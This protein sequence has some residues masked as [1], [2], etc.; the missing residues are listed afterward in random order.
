MFVVNDKKICK[1]FLLLFLSYSFSAQGLTYLFSHGFADTSKQVYR[2]TKEYPSWLG[3]KRN[4]Y[5]I[6]DGKVKLFDYPDVICKPLPNIFKTS[7]GQENEIKALKKA[8]D[9]IKDDEIVLIGVSRGASAAA[10]FAGKYKLKK[11][12]GVVL[13]SPFDTVSNVFKHHWFAWALSFMP[14]VTNKSLYNAFK[15]F[16]SYNE[17]KKSPLDWISKIDKNIPV[18]IICSKTDSTVPYRST[19]NLY[20]KLLESGHKNAYLLCVDSGKHAR[21]MSSKKAPIVQNF[22]HAFYKKYKLHHN[23]VFANKGSKL[24]KNSKLSLKK[25]KDLLK[26]Q[27]KN[28]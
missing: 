25:V 9:E 3:K 10:A 23:K 6:I 22:V 8:Y 14:F 28:K 15:K 12:K 24:L 20:K 4:K 18:S 19:V 21:L 16:S 11:L 27:A 13:F 7:L 1:L 17:K 5:Y 26:K 2:Y